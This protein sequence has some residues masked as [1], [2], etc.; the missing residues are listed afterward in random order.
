VTIRDNSDRVQALTEYLNWPCEGRTPLKANPLNPLFLCGSY[1]T[2][3]HHHCDCVQDG[4][5]LV[6]PSNRTSPP[7]TTRSRPDCRASHLSPVLV[8]GTSNPFPTP[9]IAFS[10]PSMEPS[11]ST[12]SVKALALSLHISR[13]YVITEVCTTLPSI[14]MSSPLC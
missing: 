6:L 1:R 3:L 8:L 10:P 14:S 9:V 7:F 11:H 12:H 2:S 4:H 13:V 5:L